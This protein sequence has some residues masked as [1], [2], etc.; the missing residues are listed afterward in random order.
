MMRR[1]TAFLLIVL[2]LA[3]AVLPGLAQEA[4]QFS[5]RVELPCP[6]DS[7]ALRALSDLLNVTELD[8]TWVEKDGSFELQ[9]NLELDGYPRSRTGF[10]LRGVD[11]HWSLSSP[12][13]GS[14]KLMFNNQAMIEFGLKVYHHLGFPL[15][16]LTWLYPYVHRE[17]WTA[18]LSAWEGIAGPNLRAGHIPMGDLIFVL[19]AWDE[20]RRRDRSFSVWMEALNEDTGINDFL[21]E[22]LQFIPVLLT[23]LMPDGIDILSGEDGETWL[24]TGKPDEPPLYKRSADG[25]SAQLNIPLSPGGGKL[26]VAF[27]QTPEQTLFSLSLD[28]YGETLDLSARYVSAEAVL[29][30]SLGGTCLP[31]GLRL[32]CVADGKL[33]LV[34]LEE[35]GIPEG[36]AWKL[37]IRQE[38]GNA[39]A[40]SSG[41]DPTVWLRLRWTS[42]AFVPSAW[43]AWN[44]AEL[45]GI[46]FYSI[47][48]TSMEDFIRAVLPSVLL[49]G[50]PLAAA[51]PA[52]TM[53]WAMDCL[54][55]I[56][57]L[58]LEP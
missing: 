56:G 6:A 39:W 3:G 15:Q 41:D 55:E 16:R 40:F 14:T 49:N 11:S 48:D 46:N 29:H 45:E 22:N 7:S 24:I 12:L 18:P 35:T 53:A 57:L 2:L 9:A 27:E 31:E 38:V 30:V 52:S 23:T 51:V 17:A 21:D 25:S 1:L 47:N 8:G 13:L 28:G 33:T 10:T 32:P 34:P 26:R 4:L 36:N 5:L 43:P 54:E 42:Q 44:A 19:Y 20:I 37:H 50:V 58:T